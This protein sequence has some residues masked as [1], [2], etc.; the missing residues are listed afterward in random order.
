M[1]PSGESLH[2]GTGICGSDEGASEI[3]A[4]HEVYMGPFFCWAWKRP[5]STPADCQNWIV[6]TETWLGKNNRQLNCIFF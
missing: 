5:T 4:N 3:D 1:L 6:Y 2:L